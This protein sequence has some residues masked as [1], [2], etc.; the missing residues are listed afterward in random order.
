MLSGVLSRRQFREV[1][2]T[3]FNFGAFSMPEVILLV[4]AFGFYN[5]LEPWRDA[6]C[7]YIV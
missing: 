1:F 6:A 7:K 2:F 5:E 4:A 3:A